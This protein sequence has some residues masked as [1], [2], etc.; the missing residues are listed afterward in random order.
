MKE[1]SL[2]DTV[3]NLVKQYPEIRELIISLGFEPLRSDKMLNTAGRIMT[4]GKALKRNDVP[5]ELFVETL[6]KNGF[7]VKELAISAVTVAPSESAEPSAPTGGIA[8]MGSTEFQERQDILQSLILRLHRGE[9]W[10]AVQADFK[11]HF[12]GVSAYEISVMEQGLMGKGIDAEDIQRLCNVH[13]SLFG[14]SIEAVYTTSTEQQHAGHPIQVMKL[15]NL[16]IENTLEKISKLLAVYLETKEP[17]IKK[18]IQNQLNLLGEFD[19]HYARKEYAIFPIMENKGIT[20]PPKVMW[21]VDDEIRSMFKEFRTLL[22]NEDFDAIPKAFSDLKYEMT[23]MITKEEDI[24]LPMI[25]DIFNEDH[26]L[27]IAQESDEIGYCIVKPEA[28]WVPERTLPE[29][30]SH[31]TFITE[32]NA[33][34]N[35]QT[36]HLT[37]HQ[38]EKMLNNIPLEL[39]FVD[40]DNIVRYYND[41]GEEKFFKR[42]SSAI[43][44]DVLNCHP[45][46]SLPIVTKLLADLKSGAKESESMWFRAMGKFILVTYRA[47]RDDDG[48]YM[49]TLEYVQDIQPI[50]DLDGEKRTLS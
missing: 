48:S 33:Y 26:W 46:K 9:D 42:T 44:R 19:K 27:Q 43:G 3:Y 32:E 10:D 21:G 12:T 14:G 13:A 38:L 37:P 41:N 8:R 29:N 40:A 4:I 22:Q 23:E 20:A 39:T 45:P 6:A 31:E 11:K 28:K 24:L 5:E 35:F 25:I 30:V 49:G 15:E 2:N 7:S 17:E 18:G 47:V 16:A 34:I 1:I 36:G 50:I